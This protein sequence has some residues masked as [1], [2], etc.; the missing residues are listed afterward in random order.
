MSETD[1][2]QEMMSLLDEGP[3]GYRSLRRGEVI[4]GVVVQVGRDELLVDIGT[5]A[6]AVIPASELGV[7]YAD[8]AAAAKV[9]DTILAM[10]VETE[11]REGHAILS[12][13]RAETE[14]GWRR[15][16]QLAETGETIEAEV[17]DTNRG[18]LIVHID[19]VRG[20]V[21]LSQIVDLRQPGSEEE[22]VEARLERIR[23]RTLALKVIEIN[24]RRN[25]LI[26]SERAAA[27]E[28]RMRERDRLF[29][30]LEEGQTRQGRVSSISDFGAFVD[31]GGADGL[32]HLSELSWTPVSHPG[33][34]VKIGDEVDVL[35]L[36]VDREKKKIALSLKRLRSEPWQDILTKYYPGQ[37]VPARITKLAQFGAFAEIEPGIEG[38][39]HISELS[40]ERIQHPRSVVQEDQP[41]VVKILRI[42]SERRRL[43]LSLRQAREENER[44][45]MEHMPLVYGD[46]AQPTLGDHAWISASESYG[47]PEAAPA[48]EAEPEAEPRSESG[49]STEESASVTVPPAEEPSPGNG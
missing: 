43:G 23:G 47:E 29:E 16:E 12:L 18:G 5:K 4:E 39:I 41:V 26:L 33:Q 17:V 25:R 3:S 10:V 48:P 45:E 1:S 19:G 21:P 27:Q 24:R 32:V 30:E 36:G 9:G 38:L 37:I 28:R 44:L 11:G 34:V 14:R 35:V 8:P 40:D 2:N 13:S 15:L 20:F 6:E 31:I 7:S 46:Q 42:E 22:S 49:S